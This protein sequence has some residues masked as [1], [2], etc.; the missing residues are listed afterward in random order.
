L[1]VLILHNPYQPTYS[2]LAIVPETK[3]PLV[4]E[5]EDKTNRLLILPTLFEKQTNPALTKKSFPFYYLPP[6]SSTTFHRVSVH[7]GIPQHVLPAGR[8]AI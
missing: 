7:Q 2:A 5:Q 4:L 6:T 3:P 1:V 8:A